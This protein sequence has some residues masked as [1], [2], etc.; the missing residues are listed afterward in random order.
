MILDMIKLMI[1]DWVWQW[2]QFIV[3]RIIPLFLRGKSYEYFSLIL[4]SGK[5]EYFLI[6]YFQTNSTTAF[7]IGD[8]IFMPNNR[9]PP[10][11]S[12]GRLRRHEVGHVLQ[13][14]MFG[15]FYFLIVGIPSTIRW[16]RRKI[17]NRTWAWYFQG[18]PENHAD[19]LTGVGNE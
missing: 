10:T 12:N 16:F 6:T 2:P 18:W 17:F 19:K 1:K 7:A 4:P 8:R 9:K 5:K 3:A 13:S 11:I 14:R 15:W